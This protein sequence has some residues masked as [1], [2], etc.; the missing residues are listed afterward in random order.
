MAEWLQLIGIFL[1]AFV[2]GNMI[3]RKLGGGGW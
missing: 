2:V 3:R 1:L